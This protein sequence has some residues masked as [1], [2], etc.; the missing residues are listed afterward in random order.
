MIGAYDGRFQTPIENWKASY[1]IYT[2]GR[3]TWNLQIT[4]LERKI[5]FQT[6]MIC[7]MLI[8]RVYL[9]KAGVP[10]N[11][12]KI[13]YTCVIHIGSWSDIRSNSRLYQHG[14]KLMRHWIR[15]MSACNMMCKERQNK[16]LQ[17]SLHCVQYFLKRETEDQKHVALADYLDPFNFSSWWRT[18]LWSSHTHTQLVTK[19]T[20]DM[21]VIASPPQLYPLP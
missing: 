8:F 16:G 21:H 2:P 11:H 20:Q 12:H 17:W 9:D 5:I 10:Y 15:L 13:L 6:S 19:K 14:Q 4:H 3:L 1:C 18:R 7:S